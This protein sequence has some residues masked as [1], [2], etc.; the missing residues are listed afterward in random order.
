MAPKAVLGVAEALGA[1]G[2]LAKPLTAVRFISALEAAVA[3]AG[4]AA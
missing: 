3:A 4:R 2:V 1:G